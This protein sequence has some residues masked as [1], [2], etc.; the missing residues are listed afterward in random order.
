MFADVSIKTFLDNV[1]SREPTPGG[2]SVSALCGALLAL[3][4]NG[5]ANHSRKNE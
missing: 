3:L 5:S 1:S 2:G 4:L